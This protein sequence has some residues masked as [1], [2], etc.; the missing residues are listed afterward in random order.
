MEKSQKRL[1]LFMPSIEGGGV[2]KNLIILTNYLAKKFKNIKLIT[3]DSFFKKKF[4]KRV[5]LLSVKNK[6]TTTKKYV[7]Y[8]LCLILL[9]KELKKQKCLVVSFQ[10]NIYAIITCKLLNNSIVARSNS[11]PSGW[12]DNFLKKLIFQFFLKR[13]DK[14]IVNSFEF[15]KEIDKKFNIKSK[16]I[17][18]PLDITDILKKS[19]VRIKKKLFKNRSLKI[20]NI[21]RFTDQKDHL[22]LLKAF[23]IINSKINSNLLLVG[24]GQNERLIKQ[25]IK[26]N[27]LQ[28]K[29]KIIKELNN[30]YKYLSKSDIFVLTSVFEGLPNVLLEAIVLKKPVIS[31]NCPTGPKEILNNGKYGT[32]FNIGD[33]KKLSKILLSYNKNNSNFKKKLLPAYNSLNRFNYKSK[34]LEYEKQISEYI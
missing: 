32:L 1:I 11:S 30:P 27:K 25:F 18:N 2:E 23:K 21:A 14:I 5:K 34:C 9:I 31:T 26:N 33:Y 28:N 8:F 7:K 10:A 12:S 29:I 24:Y 19:K 16:L 6:K 3:Y 13:A 4:D 22:T 20:I 17:Y 15:K